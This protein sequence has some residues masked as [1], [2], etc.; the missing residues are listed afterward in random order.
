MMETFYELKTLNP[1]RKDSFPKA[2][3]AVE[4]K[5]SDIE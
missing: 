1:E 4:I 3:E 2:R 5:F